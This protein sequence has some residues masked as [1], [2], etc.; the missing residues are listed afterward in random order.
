M[1]FSCVRRG[2]RDVVWYRVRLMSFTSA[3]TWSA[4]SG[5]GT[6]TAT[7]FEAI[8]CLCVSAF[9]AFIF[10]FSFSPVLP[11]VLYDFLIVPAERFGERKGKLYSVRRM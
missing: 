6:G 3:Q 10:V 5:Q 8:Y 11:L 4:V 7:L 2:G 9:H 1:F